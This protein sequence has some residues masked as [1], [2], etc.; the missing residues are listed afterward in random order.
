MRD[1]SATERAICYVES[2]MKYLSGSFYNCG[3]VLTVE[4]ECLTFELKNQGSCLDDWCLDLTPHGYTGILVWE[5]QCTNKWSMYHGG[6]WE[7]RLEGRWRK[8]TA[9]ELWSLTQ[10]SPPPVPA[11]PNPQ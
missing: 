6:D 7:P 9:K 1:E 5:G 8:P 10:M 4:G 11:E 2:P 3:H